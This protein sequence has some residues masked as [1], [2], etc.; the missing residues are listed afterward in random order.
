LYGTFITVTNTIQSFTFTKHESN[1]QD[2]D[3]YPK[4]LDS[5]LQAFEQCISFVGV[6]KNFG[7]AL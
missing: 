6:W 2:E 3:V 7:M 4:H 1:T 5:R